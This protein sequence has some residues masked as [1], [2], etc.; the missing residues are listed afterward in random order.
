MRF[1]CHF[2]EVFFDVFY[3]KPSFLVPPQEA[4]LENTSRET[5]HDIVPKPCK[6]ENNRCYALY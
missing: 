3:P 1:P 6:I 4:F 2:Y 5:R